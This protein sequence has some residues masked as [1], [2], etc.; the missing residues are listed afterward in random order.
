MREMMRLGGACLLALLVV[1]GV[2]VGAQAVQTAIDAA[3][4]LDAV[5]IRPSA[6]PGPMRMRLSPGRVDVSG[7]TLREL[8]GTAF[9]VPTAI[10]RYRMV[11]VEP[12][13]EAE[14]FDIMA[15]L[16]SDAPALT[17]AS[18]LLALRKLLGERFQLA[19]GAEQREGP[20]FI[21][22]LVRDGVTGTQLK[23]TTVPCAFGGPVVP[24][25]RLCDA[26]RIKGGQQFVMEGTGVTMAQLASQLGAIPAISRPV[27]DRSGLSGRH[28]FTLRWSPPL[29]IDNPDPANV[30][31]AESGP[32]IFAAL[33]EQL[34]LRLDA[35]RHIVEMLV[36]ES[37]QRPP[38]N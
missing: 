38:A 4:P 2:R 15:T 33:E 27:I 34:G 21:L 26:I 11:G 18:T 16:Q 9:G 22:S 12:W 10:P 17:M 35:G 19:V 7:A 32:S 29:P 25:A 14:R 23:P 3:P 6:S 5:S 13:M 8:I 24:P 20:A 28:D 1:A 30:S 31:G 36:I 37:A